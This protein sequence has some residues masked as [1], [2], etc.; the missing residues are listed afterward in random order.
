MAK[1]ILRAMQIMEL[2]A[3]DRPAQE[4]ARTVLMK[5]APGLTEDPTAGAKSGE[6]DNLGGTEMTDAEKLAK[7]DADRAV[8]EKALA[9]EKAANVVTKALAEMNDAEKAHYNA[10]TEI[11]AEGAKK[12]V[13]KSASERAA[14]VENA[15]AADPVMYTS[16]AGYAYRKSESRAASEAKRADETARELKALKDVQGDDVLA[17]R[18]GVEIKHLK[19]AEPAKI[20]LLKAVDGI[21]DEATRTAVLEILKAT[22][23]GLAEALKTLGTRTGKNVDDKDSPAAKIDALAKAM[24]DADKI[25]Y[26]AAYDRVIKSD[27]GRALYKAIIEKAAP[28]QG[29]DDDEDEGDE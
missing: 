23:G 6:G 9:D 25:P 5:R 18:A 8:A 27:E 17:K 10:L 12:F 1:R 2:S 20:A 24:A 29:D 21:K 13:A 28:A 7:S 19:G 15:K 3:V 26:A 16:D 4:G 11:D 14:D 22:D